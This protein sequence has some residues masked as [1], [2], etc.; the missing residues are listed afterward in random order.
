MKNELVPISRNCDKGQEGNWSG[1]L[2]QSNQ[3]PRT[4]GAFP[5]F[6]WRNKLE[7]KQ[8]SVCSVKKKNPAE[9]KVFWYIKSGIYTRQENRRA[10]G[11]LNPIDYTYVH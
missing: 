3:G 8:I 5:L 9:Q 1:Y 11:M 7:S 10:V 2:S 4:D 6:T